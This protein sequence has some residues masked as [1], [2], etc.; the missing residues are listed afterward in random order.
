MISPQWQPLFASDE[1]N[2]CTGQ[3]LH[4]NGGMAMN[5]IRPPSL[6]GFSPLAG[7]EAIGRCATAG[8]QK[9]PAGLYFKGLTPN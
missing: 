5:L 4:V 3:T 6:L 7:S 8:G 2:L 1:A 9:K